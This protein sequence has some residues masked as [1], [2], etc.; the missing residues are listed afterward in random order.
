MMPKIIWVRPERNSPLRFVVDSSEP[1]NLEVGLPEDRALKKIGDLAQPDD[2]VVV[3]ADVLD[4]VPAQRDQLLRDMREAAKPAR[5]EP[6]RRIK[7]R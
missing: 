4:Q 3:F 5:V 6:V 1:G 7:G 2:K